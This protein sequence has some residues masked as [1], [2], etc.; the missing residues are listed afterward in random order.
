MADLIE[1]QIHKYLIDQE[2]IRCQQEEKIKGKIVK[3]RNIPKPWSRNFPKSLCQDGDLLKMVT[4]F[5][6]DLS[7]IEFQKYCIDRGRLNFAK[8]GSRR[9]EFYEKHYLTEEEYL[10]DGYFHYAEEYNGK[11]YKYTDEELRTGW[12]LIM[13]GRATIQDCWEIFQGTNK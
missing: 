6:Y 10:N 11:K 9:W 5:D 1:N 13:L 12:R 3:R 8:Q 4:E 7:N 2:E